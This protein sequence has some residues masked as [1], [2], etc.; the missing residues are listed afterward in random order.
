MGINV[1]YPKRII[2]STADLTIKTTGGSSVSPRP[3][4]IE[5]DYL[6]LPVAITPIADFVGGIVMD[7]SSHRLKYNDGTEWI[8]IPKFEEIV[9]P[10]NARIDNVMSILGTKIDTVTCQESN[11]PT[12]AISGT[13]LNIVFPSNVGTNVTDITGLFTSLPAGSITGYSLVSGQN[14]ASVRAQLGNQTGRT[15]TQAKPYITS[16]GWVLADGK[17]WSWTASNGTKV[18]QVPNLN[19]NSYLKGV[20]DGGVT[21]TDAVIPYTGGKTGGT[22]ISV[23]QMANH[24]HFVPG[25]HGDDGDYAGQYMS[26]T[27]PSTKSI[28]GVDF[29]T[30]VLSSKTTSSGGGSPHDHTIPEIEPNHFNIVWL[31]NIAEP[32][33]ALSKTTTDSLYV[34]RAGDE[35]IGD[36]KLHTSGTPVSERSAVSY[37]FL[38]DN[39]GTKLNLSGGTLTGSVFAPTPLAT[40]TKQ[41]TNVEYVNNKVASIDLSPYF[42]KAGG[43]VTGFI[44][45]ETEPGTVSNDYYL[46]NKKFVTSYLSSGY[47]PLTGGT[48]TGDLKLFTTGLPSS[49]NSAVSYKYLVDSLA[50][51]LSLAGG[52]VTGP[53]TVPTPASSSTKQIA[54]VEY[55]N[56]K[57]SG[58][59][60]MD[61][62][63]ATSVTATTIG[64]TN[65]AVDNVCILTYYN[66]EHYG[67]MNVYDIARTY[68]IGAIKLASRTPINTKTEYSVIKYTTN[69]TATNFQFINGVYPYDYAGNTTNRFKAKFIDS[70]IVYTISD[71]PDKYGKYNTSTY[72][73]DMS[74]SLY[75]Y[76]AADMVNPVKAITLPR[77]S[78]S[79]VN[80]TEYQYIVNDQYYVVP[81]GAGVTHNIDGIIVN[82]KFS[83][84]ARAIACSGGGVAVTGGYTITI[85]LNGSVPY[86][87]SHGMVMKL[88]FNKTGL[89]ATNFAHSF[90][91]DANV[92]NSTTPTSNYA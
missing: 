45:H 3:V 20:A 56:S 29:E 72:N 35:M 49:L 66:Q 71:T 68:G 21:K 23:E 40:S 84:T 22:A 67:S 5:A 73:A 28:T 74:I 43:S 90:T 42:L 69:G 83:G 59:T 26:G 16:S 34:F 85:D 36:L 27:G 92:D 57:L 11:V 63:K 13:T 54:N 37:K 38:M 86:T 60:I 88:V 61:H 78:G 18:I 62:I 25:A 31:Y 70:T 4:V 9:D 17:Y 19:T 12:A 79:Y 6:R 8:T 44:T 30:G 89:S 33:L 52:A 76:N 7:S 47:L 64:T 50:N 10:I 2:T 65:L 48:L 82:C 46:V 24:E 75:F 81:A 58:T 32:E 1:D 15:G 14:Y 55:V 39:L 77:Y 41:I 51:K 91:C 87:G 53:V 80:N